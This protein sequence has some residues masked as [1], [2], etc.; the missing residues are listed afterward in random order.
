MNTYLAKN[1]LS[2]NGVLI[3]TIDKYEQPRLQLLL[4]E[5]GN[6]VWKKKIV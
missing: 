4:E 2:P 3:C 6:S 1:L 5:K